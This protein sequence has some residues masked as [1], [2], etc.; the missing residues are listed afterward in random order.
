[1][2]VVAIEKYDQQKAGRLLGVEEEQNALSVVG[3]YCK[4]RYQASAVVGGKRYKIQYRASSIQL[5]KE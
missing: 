1:M 5:N 4:E 2:K 3:A